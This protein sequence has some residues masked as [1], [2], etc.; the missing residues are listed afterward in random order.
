MQDSENIPSSVRQQAPTALT[1]VFIWDVFA[2]FVLALSWCPNMFKY[3]YIIRFV[4]C[5]PSCQVNVP[6]EAIVSFLPFWHITAIKDRSFAPSGPHRMPALVL[7]WM[8]LLS[9][10]FW[11]GEAWQAQLSGHD[12]IPPPKKKKNESHTTI[13]T[14]YLIPKA[15]LTRIKEN[16]NGY[17]TFN[18]LI[19]FT[20]GQKR[21][22]LI[23]CWI[24]SLKQLKKIVL[25]K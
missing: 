5:W 15:W 9:P 23:W 1:E 22:G 6:C 11:T 25:K 12:S 7:I 24:E 2:S 14:H 20:H 3:I 8:L 16:I 4:I 21:S 10:S 17:S 18:W 13:N 19:M